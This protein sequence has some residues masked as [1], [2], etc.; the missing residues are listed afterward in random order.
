MGLRNEDLRDGVF[1][2]WEEKELIYE[3]ISNIKVENR[4]ISGEVW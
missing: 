1:R 4:Y 2:F 3:Y